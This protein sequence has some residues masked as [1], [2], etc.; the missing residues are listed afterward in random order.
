MTFDR[1]QIQESFIN[2]VID[3]MDLDSCLDMLFD[4]L[5]QEFNSYSDNELLEEVKEVHPELL[6][7]SM[8]VK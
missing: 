5:N 3:D 4:Y 2:Q 8:T 6:E 7:E 1:E